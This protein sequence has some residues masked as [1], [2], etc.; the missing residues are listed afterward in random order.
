MKSHFPGILVVA[1][2]VALWLPAMLAQPLTIEHSQNQHPQ[3]QLHHPQH[4][5]L[6]H[7]SCRAF[8]EHCA[9]T[10]CTESKSP[11]HTFLCIEYVDVGVVGGGSGGSGSAMS[12]AATSG[13]G[14]GGGGGDAGDRPRMEGICRCSLA[15]GN[16][17]ATPRIPRTS[18]T[19]DAQCDAFLDQSTDGTATTSAGLGT[20]TTGMTTT[21]NHTAALGL[22]VCTYEILGWNRTTGNG[23]GTRR[24]AAGAGYGVDQQ[25][26]R[27]AM[28]QRAWAFPEGRPPAYVEVNVPNGLV[29]LQASGSGSGS[30][31][32]SAQAPGSTQAPAYRSFNVTRACVERYQRCQ[33]ECAASKSSS[34]DNDS[35]AVE[36]FRCAVSETLKLPRMLLAVAD[37]SAPTL[38]LA[39]TCKCADARRPAPPTP[40]PP[41]PPTAPPTPGPKPPSDG[42]DD[43][44]RDD[45]NGMTAGAIV[46]VVV[47]CVIGVAMVSFGGYRY[48]VRRYRQQGYRPL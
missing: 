6:H 10:V 18:P 35:K 22:R 41:A 12:G 13:T 21:Y 19:L 43:G 2:V 5:H 46:A 4:P 42:R 47:G 29:D 20:T 14:G 9:S 36:S 16:G 3:H 26:L 30:G 24:I 48:V 8:R 31:S 7:Q 1:F 38:P 39:S 40:A 17:T 15:A 33:G 25:E 44:S 23:T 28:F 45:R 32:A 27:Y 34:S 37:P 11:V